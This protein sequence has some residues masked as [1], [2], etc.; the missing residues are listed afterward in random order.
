MTAVV[1]S[2]H[3]NDLKLFLKKNLLNLSGEFAIS[4]VEI[5]FRNRIMDVKSSVK[6]RSTSAKPCDILLS[7]KSIIG[8]KPD[9]RWDTLFSIVWVSGVKKYS[10]IF[11]EEYDNKP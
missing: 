5:S 2:P 6:D 9:Q 7:R 4:K 11:E 8:L 3:I 1:P 10:A